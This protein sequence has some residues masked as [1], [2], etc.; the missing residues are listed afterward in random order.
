MI[1]GL[2][3]ALLLSLGL[4]W[5]AWLIVYRSHSLTIPTSI[6]V[7]GLAPATTPEV[8]LTP[9]LAEGIT[10]AHADQQ[11]ALSE[12]QAILIAGQLEPDA[13][14]K[15]KK[16]D[17]RYVL[18]NY[19]GTAGTPGTHAAL[20]NVPVWIVWYQ[21]V[22]LEPTDASVDPTPFPHSYHD[23]Y[24]FLDANSGKELLSIWI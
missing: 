4:L 2:V 24:V 18:L 22:P 10:L 19:P 5:F 9:L 1:T 14:S 12:Q 11:P 3:G 6:K 13:A 17:A 16:T 20:R 15:A 8:Q 21:Q 7:P 23:L